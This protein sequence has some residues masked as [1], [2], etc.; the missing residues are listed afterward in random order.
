MLQ[1]LRSNTK[2]FAW[3]FVI[4]LVLAFGLSSFTFNKHDQYAGEVFGKQ[5]SFQ[6]FRIFETLTRLLAPDPSILEDAQTAYT[7][8]WQ[9]LILSREAQNQKVEV[10]DDEVRVQVDQL[11]NRQADTRLSPGE[12][13]NLL[14]SWRTTPHEFESGVREMIRVNKMLSSLFQLKTDPSSFAGNDADKKEI[15]LRA[16]KERAELKENYMRWLSELNQKAAVVDYSKLNQT[17]SAPE[18]TS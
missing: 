12:Y 8:A 1:F 4:V 7:Y 2:I 9:Q 15:L 11:M 10:S 14:K 18:G 6:E 13:T 17:P 5:V 16:E 3:F